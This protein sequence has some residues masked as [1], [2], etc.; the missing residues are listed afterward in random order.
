VKRHRL[1]FWDAMIIQSAKEL[2]CKVTWTEDLN[3]G[4]DYDGVKILNPFNDVL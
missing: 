4:Q 3:A 2:G 1:S